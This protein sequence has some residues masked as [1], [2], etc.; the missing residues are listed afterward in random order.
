[1]LT[2]APGRV[3]GPQQVWHFPQAACTQYRALGGSPGIPPRGR[4]TAH[5]V[6]LLPPSLSF[7]S[8]VE[9]REHVLPLTLL[10]LPLP[11]GRRACAFQAGWS[12]GQGVEK[13]RECYHG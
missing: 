13:L 3:A 11:V 5:S 4:V 1:M 12:E 6:F 10:R 2:G 8:R 9:K 7:L